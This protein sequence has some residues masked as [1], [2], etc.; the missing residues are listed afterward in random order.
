[1]SRSQTGNRNAFLDMI[2]DSE[3]GQRILAG[4]DDGYNVEVGSTPDNIILI[5]NYD[6][7]PHIVEHIH[8]RDGTD[9]PSSAAGRYQALGHIFDSYRKSLNLQ[10]PYFSPENQDAVTIQQIRECHAL[11][12]IDAGNIESAIPKVAHL[13]ASFPGA[14]YKDQHMNKITQLLA[15]FTAAGGILA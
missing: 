8:R 15:A 4:S 2:A 7:H 10:A 12:D 3:L 1:M 6:D 9:I 14:G 11:P 13:W 5:A